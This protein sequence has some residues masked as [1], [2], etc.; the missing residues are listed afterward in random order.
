MNESFVVGLRRDEMLRRRSTVRRVRMISGGITLL[1][2]M[3]GLALSIWL[4]FRLDGSWAMGAMMIACMVFLFGSSLVPFVQSGKL[5]RW[6]AGA[7]L[8]PYALRMTA[9]GLELGVEGAPAPVVLPWPAVVGFRRKRKLGQPLLQVVVQ[10]GVTAGS[11]GVSGLDQPVV[12]AL[13]RRSRRVKTAGVYSVAS[14]DQPVEAI[15][16]ALRYFSNG[17]AA[18]AR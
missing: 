6:Y 12:Q 10:P 18:V 2:S 13:L 15:D 8:P 3:A 17:V 7:D 4:T 1:I 14:L 11:P 16:Q 9:G 5:K